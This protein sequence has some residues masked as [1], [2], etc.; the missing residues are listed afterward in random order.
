VE[1]VHRRRIR[2]KM[3]DLE[4]RMSGVVKPLRCSKRKCGGL[5]FEIMWMGRY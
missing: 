3:Y 1:A 2:C 4:E 5:V